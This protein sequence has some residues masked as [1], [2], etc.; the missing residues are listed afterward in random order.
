MGLGFY[1]T[2]IYLDPEWVHSLKL[3]IND[4]ISVD[5]VSLKFSDYKCFGGD[6]HGY[7]RILPINLIIGRN[8]TGK[9]SLIDLIAYVIQPKDLGKFGFKRQIPRVKVSNNLTKETLRKVFSQGMGGGDIKGDHWEFG[10]AWIGRPIVLE[11]TPK[12]KVQFVEIDPPMNVP[13]GWLNK[14]AESNGNPFAGYV[15]KRLESDRDM[16]AEA[17]SQPTINSNGVGATNTI[18][19]F[20][21]KEGLPSA[22][23]EETLLGALNTIFEPEGRFTRIVV[24]Q[25]ENG[26]WEVFLEEDEKGWVPL[27]NSGSGIKTILL[28]L[29]FLH[30]IPYIDQKPLSDYLFG[31]EELENNLH[32]ALQRRLF[33]YLREFA[34][35]QACKVFLSTHSNVAI[36]LFANDSNSQ[37]LHVTHDRKSATV[38]PVVTYI[39]NKGILDDLDIRASDLLQANGIVWLEDPSDRLYFNRWVEVFSDGKIREGAHYQCVYYGGRLLAHLSASDPNTNPEDV[40]KILRV[41]RNA[42]VIADSDRTRENG[43]I[44]DTKQR[45]LSEI[46]NVG[47]IGWITAGKEVEN[48]I[49]NEAFKAYYE[50]QEIAPLGQYQ[51]IEDY[52]DNIK[53]NEGKWF[54]KNKVLFAERICSWINKNGMISTLDL[55]NQMRGACSL[56]KTWNGYT[57]SAT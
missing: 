35:K 51:D 11:V 32:P 25:L 29:V 24:Q 57:D 46:A 7:D 18:Q 44:N 15:F 54:S 39:D 37:I 27:S 47:G 2:I 6:G 22:L 38:K 41:N 48:Y 28:V 33:L 8:N 52:L 17:D 23:V 16:I 1:G 50:S 20:L 42:M 30:L 13:P 10:K 45:I 55:H 34:V 21:N 49:P 4:M 36:D 3:Q 53:A 9:S 31:F 40:I 56:I 26:R 12:N 5:S 19:N 43:P 14:L